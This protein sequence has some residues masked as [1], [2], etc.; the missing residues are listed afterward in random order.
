VFC[1]HR[2]AGTGLRV[3][4][5]RPG[6][7]SH[8]QVEAQAAHFVTPRH[9][10]GLGMVQAMKA[11]ESSQ[12]EGERLWTFA[13]AC[14]RHALGYAGLTEFFWKSWR[15]SP[16]RTHEEVGRAMIEQD[17]TRRQQQA[18]DLLSRAVEAAAPQ[19]R[20]GREASQME[21]PPAQ[22]SAKAVS[23]GQAL[24]SRRNGASRPSRQVHQTPYREALQR[25]SDLSSVRSV[26][27][28]AWRG[29][30][31]GGAGRQSEGV[32]PA[33]LLERLGPRRSGARVA[34]ARVNPP[35]GEAA[36]VRTVR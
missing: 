7:G 35:A 1:R 13:R 22:A 34:G 31:P 15:V 5:A 33:G 17:Q 6:G 10:V 2:T 14:L 21:C 26:S 12:R 8:R 30:G 11:M 19:G 16:A 9:F 36:G 27:A 18:Q 29:A 23:F 25:F 28:Y 32:Q 4:R 24:L 20:A 3:A